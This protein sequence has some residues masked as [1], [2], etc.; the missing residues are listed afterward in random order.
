MSATGINVLLGVCL[1]LGFHL[2]KVTL[3]VG[4]FFLQF[5]NLG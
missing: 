5:C 2:L 1:T 3:T 4:N